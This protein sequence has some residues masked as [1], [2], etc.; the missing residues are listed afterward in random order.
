MSTA[1]L[2]SAQAL[3]DANEQ[4]FVE[5]NLS[6]FDHSRAREAAIAGAL[7]AMATEMGVTLQAPLQIDSRGE[8]S[9]IAKKSDGSDPRLGAGG[10]GEAFA[11][12]LNRHG[13]RT[14][15][16]PGAV[17]TAEAGWCWLNHFS[18]E[19]MVL[20]HLQGLTEAEGSGDRSTVPRS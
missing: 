16:S 9:I 15:I 14:G 2:E 10:Y 11:A 17:M 18:A 7:A 5:R 3:V 19:K 13:P 12:A 6:S 8:F 1:F 4:F 20:D